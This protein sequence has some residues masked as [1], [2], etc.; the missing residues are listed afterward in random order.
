[1]ECEATL[2]VEYTRLS[3]PATCRTPGYLGEASVRTAIALSCCWF[4]L[5]SSSATND[6]GCDPECVPRPSMAYVTTDAANPAALPCHFPYAS[7]LVARDLGDDLG[8]VFHRR[9]PVAHD[10]PPPLWR[11]PVGHNLPG[12]DLHHGRQ[13]SRRSSAPRRTA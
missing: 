1:M 6:F 8:G 2:G 5:S 11:T 13:T 10:H 7:Q 9:R 4:P 12:T 3:A